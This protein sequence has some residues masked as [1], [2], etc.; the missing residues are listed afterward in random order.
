MVLLISLELCFA[1]II[2]EFNKVDVFSY[3]IFQQFAPLLEA[4]LNDQDQ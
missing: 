1:T 4:S 3:I 2:L